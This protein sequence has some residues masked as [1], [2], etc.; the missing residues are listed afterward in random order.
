MSSTAITV[1]TVGTTPHEGQKPG[2]SGLRKR[3]RIFQQPNYTDN[4]VQAIFDATQ[5]GQHGD[6]PSL[7]VGGDGRYFMKETIQTIIRI[8]IANGIQR[9][10][11]GKDGI[12]S[13]PAGSHLIRS[14]GASG[15]ILLTA[16]HNPGGP[17]KDF[18]IKFNAHN[19][20]PAPENV[21]DKIYECTRAIRHYHIAEIPDVDISALGSHIVGEINGKPIEVE[22]VDSVESYVELLKTIFDFALIKRFLKENPT[23]KVLFDGLNGVTGPYGRS[24]FVKEFGLPETTSVDQ[25]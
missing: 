19:G 11:V 9:F 18:G 10:I 22:V 3:V 24:L 25:A 13:T 8:G 4:F 7:V 23:F 6:A 17:E 20:G 1:K 14:L 5:I 2:T 21:T 15:G 16:S 12:L